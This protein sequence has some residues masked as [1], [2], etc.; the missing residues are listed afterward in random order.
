VNRGRLFVD[1]ERAH[2]TLPTNR[3]P[4]IIRLVCC[5]AHALR[6]LP[7]PCDNHGGKSCTH[8]AASSDRAQ[9]WMPSAT[10][11]RQT[12]PITTTAV[13]SPAPSAPCV[14]PSTIHAGASARQLR[15]GLYKIAVRSRRGTTSIPAWR[16]PAQGA[17]R[18][19]SRPHDDSISTRCPHHLAA[20]NP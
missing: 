5:R 6:T 17:L 13:S 3:R 9:L 11:R 10:H 8:P 2:S 15:S 12:G 7:A 19:G 18:T 16:R 14:G 1:G 20:G 4:P